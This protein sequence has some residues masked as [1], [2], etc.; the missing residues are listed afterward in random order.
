MDNNPIKKN[1][2]S[3]NTVS[4]MSIQ[5]VSYV[6]PLILVSFLTRTIGIETYGLF[7]F[8]MSFFALAVVCTDFG[9]EL[10]APILIPR[11]AE[12]KEKIEEFIGAT[13]I[14]KFSLFF[15]LSFIVLAFQEFAF[16]NKD[17]QEVL[18]F[19]LV[20][21]AGMTLQPTFFFMG[22]EKMSMITLPY[23]VSRVFY[24]VFVLIFIKFPEDL[25]ILVM[26]FGCSQLISALIGV[27]I[28]FNYGYKIRRPSKRFFIEVLE[29]SSG[30]FFSRISGTAYSSGGSFFLGLVALPSLVAYFALAE[31]VFRAMQGLFVPIQQALIPFISRTKDIK[32]FK[33]SFIVSILSSLI[34]AMACFLLREDIVFLLS[35]Q[36]IDYVNNILSILIIIF[37]INISS[38]LL[39]YPFLGAL[40]YSS[41]VN[42]NVIIGGILYI[43]ILTLLYFYNYIGPFQIAISWLIIETIILILR[44]KKVFQIKTLF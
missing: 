42:K 16:L 15:I 9:I 43:F 41:F 37:L 26:I 6:L 44:I 34:V 13:Y 29:G 2:L 35:G 40:G 28:I 4:L 27:I 5:L 33:F 39:G 12:K 21:I 17:Y 10:Y 1:S 18:L 38:S 23:V 36:R 8:G 22:L 24:V 7:A 31:L 19:F 32:K 14:L 30:Y 20:P 3:S 11:I 25:K